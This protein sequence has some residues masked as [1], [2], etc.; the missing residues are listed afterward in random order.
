MLSFDIRSL[1]AHAAVVDEVLSADDPVWGQTDR[2]PID[3]VRVS[4]RLSSAGQGRFYWHGRLDGEVMLECSRCLGDTTVHVADEAHIIFAEQGSDDA[5]DPDVYVY[6]PTAADLDLRPALREEWLLAAP[7]Y[8]V[9]R[10]DCKGL[11][12]RCGVDL[13]AGPHDCAEQGT[14]SRWDAL[15]N[16]N[17]SS[18]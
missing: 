3:G 17:L 12:P 6:E 1:E 8:A 4:G 11:C 9:C 10:T 13:N 2:K 18:R 7:G 16:L 5:D 15:K 14:D